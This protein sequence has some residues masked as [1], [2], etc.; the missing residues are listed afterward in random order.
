VKKEAYIQCNLSV[1][2]YFQYKLKT[3]KRHKKLPHT[4]AKTLK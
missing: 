2:K 3:N 1:V 4:T